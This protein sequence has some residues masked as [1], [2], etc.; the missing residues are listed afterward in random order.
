MKSFQGYLSQC[1]QSEI[2]LNNSFQRNCL[3]P[4][5]LKQ[6]LDEDNNYNQ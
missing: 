5:P 2:M 3:R 4:W 1:F 6:K